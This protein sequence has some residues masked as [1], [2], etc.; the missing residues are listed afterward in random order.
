VKNMVSCESWDRAQLPDQLS[1]S[2]PMS[3]PRSTYCDI[4]LFA[5]T[6]DRTGE[7]GSPVGIEQQ[8]HGGNGG[9]G[10]RNGRV[11]LWGSLNNL[12]RSIRR[13]HL[14]MSGEDG[15]CV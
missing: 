7:D 10:R 6:M 5:N 14:R 4:F 12:P 3:A 8:T 9:V 15:D 13:R 1:I 11:R 2:K